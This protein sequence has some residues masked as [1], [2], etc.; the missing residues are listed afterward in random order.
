MSEKEKFYRALKCF[1]YLLIFFIVL[2]PI[3]L[4]IVFFIGNI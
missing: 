4:A 1:I 2:I 3:L